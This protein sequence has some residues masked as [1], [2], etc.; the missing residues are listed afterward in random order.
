MVAHD[1][2]HACKWNNIFSIWISFNY[3]CKN[4][5][6]GINYNQ[7]LCVHK[8]CQNSLTLSFEYR[9]TSDPY[10]GRRRNPYVKEKQ[11]TLPFWAAATGRICVYI[12]IIW[13]LSLRAE[14]INIVPVVAEADP[15]S[16][17]TESKKESMRTN[18]SSET[19][20]LCRP[21]NA[22]FREQ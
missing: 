6:K 22:F 11:W 13:C 3:V 9:T 14:N 17:F 15:E 18:I 2:L 12:S 1:M 7:T 4:N 5:A 10:Y 8:S 21:W 16:P 19:P 20:L